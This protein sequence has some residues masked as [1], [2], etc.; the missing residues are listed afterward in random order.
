MSLSDQRILSI[1]A[2]GQQTSAVHE[3][4]SVDRANFPPVLPSTAGTDPTKPATGENSVTEKVPQRILEIPPIVGLNRRQNNGYY[5]Y[6]DS[7]RRGNRF[8]G[9]LPGCLGTR[10]QEQAPG[11]RGTQE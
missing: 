9:N 10:A 7:R 3:C 4:N 6:L 2:S 1:R 5:V 11:T 8:T